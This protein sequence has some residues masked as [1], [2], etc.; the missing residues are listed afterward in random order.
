MSEPRLEDDDLPPTG[1]PLTKEQRRD[2]LAQIERAASRSEPPEAVLQRAEQEMRAGRLDAAKRLLAYL[3]ARSP[4][5]AGLA[6]LHN[7]LQA[8]ETNAKQ[9]ANVRKAEEMLLRYVQERKKALAQFALDALLEL[10][11][12][13]PRKHDYT[14]WIADL[15]QEVA[16][17]KRMDAER[18]AG[19][20]ALHAGDLAGARGRLDALRKL[21]ADATATAQ[22]AHELEELER[23]RAENASIERHRHR[24]EELIGSLDL[25]EAERELTGLG[26]LNVPKVTLDFLRRR[27]EDARGRVLEASHLQDFEK[28]FRD[29]LQAG[30]WQA[31]RDVAHEVGSRFRGHPRSPEMFDEVTRL[32]AE[33]RRRQSLEQGIRALEGFIANRQRRE[34]EL[35]LRVLHGLDLDPQRL[36]AYEAKIRQL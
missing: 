17:Q 11:P 29:H 25:E 1:S 5:L 20:A 36:A 13:H 21:D 12:E 7:R 16:M 28:T 9:N 33:A 26:R 32:E 31:A 35:A 6:L 24:F 23:G 18:D 15:D 10:V 34:A 8:A 2:L 4:E 27:L 14:I 30:R 3:Q 19:R 22:L